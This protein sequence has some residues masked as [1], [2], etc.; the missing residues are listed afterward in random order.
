VHFKGWGK[1]APLTLELQDAI[2]GW[3]M[4][5]GITDGEIFPN[6]YQDPDLYDAATIV[7]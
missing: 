4:A 7:F 6:M 3:V 1:D 2:W 5:A